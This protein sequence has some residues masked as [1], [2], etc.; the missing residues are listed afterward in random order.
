MEDDIPTIGDGGTGV[1]DEDTT[2]EELII[3]PFDASLIRVSTRFL[4]VGQLIDRMVDKAINLSPDFQ[5]EFVWK[6]SAQSRLIESMF[7]RFPLPA[8]YMDATDDERWLVVDGLQ[9]LSSVK[10]FA[11]DKTLRL[12]DLEFLGEQYNNKSYDELPAGLKRRI[13]ETQVT[14]YLIEKGTPP[15][16]KFNIFKRINTGGL[17]LSPQE[18][19]HA[20]HQG[21]ITILLKN[22]ADSQEF[23]RATNNGVQDR[24]MG[25]REMVMRFLAFSLTPY[26]SYTKPDL[27]AF[28]NE[29]MAEMNNMSAAEL[30]SWAQRFLRVMKAAY[31]IFGK[32]AFRKYNVKTNHWLFINKALFEAWSVNLGKLNDEQLSTLVKHKEKVVTKL[33]ELLND[34]EFD[35]AISQGTGDIRKVEKRFKA[36][37]QLIAEVLK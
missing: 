1:E 22:L 16:V 34:R 31:N 28:L 5:R 4:T 33:L 9:R 35:S 26:T 20:L 25:D 2:G 13:N 36:V 29:K 6:D 7:I 37:E 10:R 23:K 8:F 15:D 24:R 11:I 12:T 18:I 32:G 21:P 14:L 30:E 19:R 27:D 3:K 17:P